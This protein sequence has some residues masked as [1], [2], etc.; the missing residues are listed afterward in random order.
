MNVYIIR[1]TFAVVFGAIVLCNI[2]YGLI[3]REVNRD[4]TEPERISRFENSRMFEVLEL[5]HDAYPKSKKRAAVWLLL[6]TAFLTIGMA[7]V[8]SIGS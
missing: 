6:G 7:I 3:L 4:R 1:S 5:H 2:V 8:D